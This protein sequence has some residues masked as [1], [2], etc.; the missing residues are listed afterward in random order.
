MNHGDIDP[1][2][3]IDF[4]F[5]T[6]DADGLPTTLA[7]TP[8][9]TVYKDNS[10]TQSAVGVTL[11]VDFDS[12][13]GQ[14]HVRIDTAADATFYGAGSNFQVQIA[15]GTVDGVSVVGYSVREFSI[16]KRSALRPTTKGN[17]LDVS[18]EGNAGLDLAN[19]ANPTAAQTLTG[20]T[21]KNVGD[22]SA[23]IPPALINNRID[24]FVSDMDATLITEISGGVSPADFA[25]AVLDELLAGHAIANSLGSAV[26]TIL[27]NVV[28]LLAVIRPVKRNRAIDIPFTM[29]DSTGRPAINK[30]ITARRALDSITMIPV[31]GTVEW[32]VGKL[33][34][35]HATAADTNGVVCNYEWTCPGQSPAV[36]DG[37]KTIYTEQA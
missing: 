5:V 3:I 25:D 23:R 8:S 20:L 4:K 28:A 18:D 9:L 14:H 36:Q 26:S 1:G 35:L 33:Y 16:Q 27:A 24:A 31:T 19:I 12:V 32:V 13:T 7:G 22:I 2:D 21:I 30:V 37:Y 34:V 15:A 17:T 11:T 6:T 10:A 29:I